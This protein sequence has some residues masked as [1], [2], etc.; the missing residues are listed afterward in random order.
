MRH[1][2]YERRYKEFIRLDK[3]LDEVWQKQRQLPLIPYDKPIQNGWTM[4]YELRS[5]IARRDDAKWIQMALDTGYKPQ[6]LR[7]VKHVRMI[8]AGHKGYYETNYKG[9][10]Y[11]VSFGPAIVWLKKEQYEK[12]HPAVKKYFYKP[13]WGWWEY[14]NHRNHYKIEI[15]QFW[16]TVKVRPHYL[17]H[18]R[19]IDPNL[20]SRERWL[21][22]K[23]DSYYREFA[24]SYHKSY[25]AY[26]DRAKVRTAIKNFMIG[27]T[28]DIPIEKIP[29]EYDF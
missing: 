25:P 22:D 19:N 12:L 1:D 6:Y 23:L 26:K 2:K 10:K 27:A 17:T 15:P 4:G 11:W 28:E 29:L 3:E 16:L 8:R 14:P 24:R 18:Y 5:D 13:I 9:K 21:R 7:S 20:Q